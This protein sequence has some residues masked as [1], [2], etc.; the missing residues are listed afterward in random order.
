MRIFAA[1]NADGW[2]SPLSI[3]NG[4]VEEHIARKKEVEKYVGNRRF[5][6]GYA[7]DL[8]LTR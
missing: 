7:R 4:N 3:V 6:R 8:G 1:K 2:V 5:S